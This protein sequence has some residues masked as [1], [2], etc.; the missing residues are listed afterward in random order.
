MWIRTIRFVMLIAVLTAPFCALGQDTPSLRAITKVYIEKMPNDLDQYL[1]AEIAKQFKGRLIVVLDKKDA[2]G[3]LAGIDDEKKGTGAQITG[4]YLGLHDN[5][6][7]TLSMLDKNE[8]MILWTDEA[9]DR[10]LLFGV[11]KRGGQR[12]VADRLISKLKK[13]MEK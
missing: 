2:D 3:I 1:R 5:A 13:A 12:K 9:G 10:S 7:G 11:M 4:R 6:T 8:K